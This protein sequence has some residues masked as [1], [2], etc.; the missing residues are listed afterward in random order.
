V[1]LRLVLGMLADGSLPLDQAQI[2]VERLTREFNDRMAYWR[3]R[4][5]GAPPSVRAVLE[6]QTGQ[7]LVAAA[8]AALP[9]LGGDDPGAKAAALAAVHAL[10]QAHRREVDGQVEVALSDAKAADAAS[11]AI[12][13]QGLIAVLALFAAAVAGLLVAGRRI[14]GDI[15]RATGGEPAQAAAV[16]NAVAQGDLAV[17]VPTGAGDTSSVLAAMARM[18]DQLSGTVEAVRRASDGIAIGATQIAS[19]NLDLSNRTERQAG[20]LQQTA[21]AMDQ[22]SGTIRNTAEAAH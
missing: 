22:F 17:A 14:V 1:E 15:W 18:R 21:S 8:P 10:Y 5:E 4:S 19:G 20:N 6:G 12:E 2:E 13:R 3:Q 7:R 16:A 11:A 9:A